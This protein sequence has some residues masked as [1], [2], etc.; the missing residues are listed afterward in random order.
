[1]HS[2][3]VPPGTIGAAMLHTW[4]QSAV[5]G[6][7]CILFALAHPNCNEQDRSILMPAIF[8]VTDYHQAPED[9]FVVQLKGGAIEVGSTEGQKEIIRPVSVGRVMD[10]TGRGHTVRPTR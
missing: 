6:T 7:C 8:L 3:L 4:Q 10:I 5:Y 2:S 1:M 9:Q